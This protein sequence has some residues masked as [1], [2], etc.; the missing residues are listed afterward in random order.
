[1]SGASRS[2]HEQRAGERATVMLAL[3]ATALTSTIFICGGLFATFPK[4]A[5]I[6]AGVATTILGLMY[7]AAGKGAVSGYAS[8]DG[9]LRLEDL[10]TAWAKWGVSPDS[11][12]Y[13][14]GRGGI[15]PA[16]EYFTCRLDGQQVLVIEGADH[17][18]SME[19]TRSEL[20]V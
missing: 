10:A 4:T 6:V 8:E 13:I 20:P 14:A 12:V 1:M 3:I 17:A 18:P 11:P 2:A 16:R 7:A 19:Q 5:T 15:Q 9:Y